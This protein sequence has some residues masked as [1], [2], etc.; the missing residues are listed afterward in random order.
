[1]GWRVILI[2]SQSSA[3]AIGSIAVFVIDFLPKANRDVSIH[4]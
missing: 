3:S 4:H 2:T 1:M